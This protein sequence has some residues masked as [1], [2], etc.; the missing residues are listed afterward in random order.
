M[1]PP[2]WSRVAALF[3]A[4]VDL[5]PPERDEEIDRL[6]G[7]DAPL[8][9]AVIALLDEHDRAESERFLSAAPSPPVAGLEGTELG[10][11]RL[12]RRIGQG[13]MGVVFE[14]E[15]AQPRRRVAVKVLKP[16]LSAGTLARRFEVEAEV[17][18]RLRH[19]GIAQVFASGVHRFASG[20]LAFDLPWIAMELLEGATTLVEHAATRG[21]DVERRLALF[22]NVCAA[23]T[24]AHRRGVI[25]RDLKPANVLV[26]ATGALKVIDFGI[27]HVT[28]LAGVEA[29]QATRAGDLLGTLRAMAPEQVDGRADQVD[30]R[31]DVYALGVLLCELLTGEA[32]LAIDD[33]TIDAAVRAIRLDPPRRPSRLR[34][35]LP[36][37]IDWIVARCVEKDPDRRYPSVADLALDLDRLARREL[38]SVGPAGPAYRTATFV[39]R[40]RIAV[41]IA[42]AGLLLLAGW[43]GSL[44]SALDRALEA[45]SRERAAAEAATREAEKAIAVMGLMQYAI[46]EGGG[47][48]SAGE[49]PMSEVVRRMEAA[50]GVH[51]FPPAVDAAICISLA[52]FD[53]VLDAPDRADRLLDRAL[54][55]LEG[56]GLGDSQ[57]ARDARLTKATVARLRG[58]LAEAAAQLD[59]ADRMAAAGPG[60]SEAAPRPMLDSV[61]AYERIGLLVAEGRYAAAE[62]LAREFVERLSGERMD[63]GGNLPVFQNSL[64]GILAALGR[65]EEA[66]A[67][68]RAA[69]DG[70]QREHADQPARAANARNSLAAVL[71]DLGRLEE[72][73]PIAAAAAAELDAELG[74]DHRKTL[75][76]RS[77]WARARSGL[78]DH[79]AAISLARDVLAR[80]VASQGERHPE[81]AA[82]RILLG[83]LLLAAARPSE[84]EP[85]LVAAV[86][87]A[88]DVLAER[89]PGRAYALSLLGRTR[90]DRGDRAAGRA[91]LEA[92]RDALRSDL[93]PE[94]PH[95]RQIEE[96]LGSDAD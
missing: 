18:A 54:D 10:G 39:R 90:L 75:A 59:A 13:G 35:G 63:P 66:E 50:V 83:R 65:A 57:D 93:P 46:G 62:P 14:A 25:H 58:R 84:A 38:L 49:V 68:A 51:S 26:D 27:A 89:H 53:L 1:I 64:T 36:R 22:R 6:A 15:Q 12:V 78:G 55:R 47:D 37:E 70:E 77:T 43:I 30:V 80:R 2:D 73:E 48:R 96:W 86:E 4:L 20:P 34:A 8:R 5:D 82:T 85:E 11:F 60:G 79:D 52:G 33:S 88:N 3:E 87:L 44:R 16:A 71:V 69:L 81:V 31:T 74:P 28:G 32:P 17:L 76:A 45:E 41:A 9:V 29:T 67:M 95:L 40:H 7:E 61:A 91:A 23:V 19:P 42:A 24:H 92:A 72:A 21:L 56:A 94:H